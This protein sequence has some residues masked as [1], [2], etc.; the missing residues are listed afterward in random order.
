MIEVI[1]IKSGERQTIEVPNDMG[2]NLMELLKGEAY[3]TIEGICGGMALCA[4]CH[5]KIARL[6][7]SGQA[8]QVAYFILINV[9]FFVVDS[10]LFAY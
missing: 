2:L 7:Y 3:E 1:I 8:S 5:I 10:S 4:T 6:F 9:I